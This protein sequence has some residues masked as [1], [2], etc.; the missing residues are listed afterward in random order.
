MESINQ[1]KSA[2]KLGNMKKKKFTIMSYFTLRQH[3]DLRHKNMSF[4]HNGE[5]QINYT[6]VRQ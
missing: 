2:S 5:T 1:S 4:N 6:F 3:Q